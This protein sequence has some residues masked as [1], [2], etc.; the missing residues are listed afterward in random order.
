MAV[1]M[2]AA[3]AAA[4][5]APFPSPLHS[6]GGDVRGGFTDAHISPRPIRAPSL[7]P[8]ACLCFLPCPPCPP[9]RYSELA[10]AVVLVNNKATGA[11]SKVRTAVDAIAGL[12]SLVSVD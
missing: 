12:L 10:M 1:A 6:F 2:A 9:E 8:L 3:I 5:T 11:N 4:V 7:P